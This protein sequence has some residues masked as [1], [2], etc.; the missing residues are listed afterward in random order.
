MEQGPKEEAR[1][2]DGFW[3]DV[4]PIPKIRIRTM[5]CVK[6]TFLTAGAAD[7]AVDTAEALQEE[8]AA[9]DLDLEE[10]AGNLKR[11]IRKAAGVPDYPM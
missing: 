8:V 9:G 1:E 3:E 4:L 7:M 2:Q 6:T 11:I 10:D 5:T